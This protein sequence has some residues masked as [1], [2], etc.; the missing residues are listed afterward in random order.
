MRV[1]INTA[2]IERN[3]LAL[4]RELGQ[5]ALDELRQQT[6]KGGLAWTGDNYN[7]RI[8]EFVLYPCSYFHQLTFT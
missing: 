8:Y 1:M 7:V 2:G 4:S 5:K 3:L 6:G